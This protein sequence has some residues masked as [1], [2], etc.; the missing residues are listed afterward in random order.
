MIAIDDA[1]PFVEAVGHTIHG[2]WAQL[3]RLI[4]ALSQPENPSFRLDYSKRLSRNK[5]CNQQA[6]GEGPDINASQST[7]A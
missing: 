5:V 3:L 1:S 4:D 7:R 6:T 2:G